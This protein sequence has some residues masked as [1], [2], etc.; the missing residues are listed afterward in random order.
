MAS[1]IWSLLFDKKKW[2]PS[3][4]K[5]WLKEHA[6]EM[7]KAGFIPEAL[8]VS[9]RYYRAV[10]GKRRRPWRHAYKWISR[11]QGIQALFGFTGQRNPAKRVERTIAQE[12]IPRNVEDVIY[13]LQGKGY[14]EEQIM[15][16]I[17]DLPL[18]LNPV[19][20]AG[21]FNWMG[22][23]SYRVKDETGAEYYRPVEKVEK[24]RKLRPG[25]YITKEEAEEQE[26]LKDLELGEKIPFVVHGEV[27]PGEG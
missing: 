26:R 19:V 4:I 13:R 14:T 12:D 18:K 10:G 17:S 6:E 11:D 9:S 7:A 3:K 27:K 22:I 20:M 21:P 5:K 24:Y 8:V 25:Y 16:I 23:P 2:N 1:V 15:N